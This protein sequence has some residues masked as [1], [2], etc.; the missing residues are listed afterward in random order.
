MIY[1]SLKRNCYHFDEIV[2]IGCTGIQITTFSADSNENFTKMTIFY[3]F[4]I[5]SLSTPACSLSLNNEERCVTCGNGASKKDVKEAT[6]RGVIGLIRQERGGL[7]T[8][9]GDDT[10]KDMFLKGWHRARVDVTS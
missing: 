3:I 5:M 2:I 7:S 6:W 8:S 1:N 10:D 4:I 9:G